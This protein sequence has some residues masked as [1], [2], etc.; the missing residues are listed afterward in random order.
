MEVSVEVTGYYGLLW[1]RGDSF[2]YTVLLCTK[3]S[4]CSD[5][6]M[7]ICLDYEPIYVTHGYDLCLCW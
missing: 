7:V 6:D 2:H 5:K 1:T 3:F 4:G